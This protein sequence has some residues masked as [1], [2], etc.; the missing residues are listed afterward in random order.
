MWCS[1]KARRSSAFLRCMKTPPG[2]RA[3]ANVTPEKGP[4]RADASANIPPSTTSEA[5]CLLP[6]TMPSR[7]SGVEALP[8]TGTHASQRC[9]TSVGSRSHLHT[10]LQLAPDTCDEFAPKFSKSQMVVT[11]GGRSLLGERDVCGGSASQ[12]QRSRVGLHGPSEVHAVECHTIFRG[13]CGATR[14][15]APPAERVRE[16]CFSR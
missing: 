7:R 11:L 4:M 6:M 16:T 5:S 1:T 8:L 2:L 10:V 14:L 9:P 15:H 12:V 13:R 3:S